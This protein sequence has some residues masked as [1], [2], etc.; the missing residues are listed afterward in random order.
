MS[1][2]VDKFSQAAG[3]ECV[4]SKEAKINNLPQY[5]MI[6]MVRFFYKKKS[7]VAGTDATHTKILRVRNSFNHS[8]CQ[9]PKDHGSL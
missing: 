8:E 7:E 4:Y 6:H 2:D 9:F 1:G 3:R 5:A